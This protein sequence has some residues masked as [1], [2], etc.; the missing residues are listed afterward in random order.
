[1]QPH[2]FHIQC[3]DHTGLVA[4]MCKRTEALLMVMTLCLLVYAAS[5]HRIR[6]ELQRQSRFFPD[7]KRKPYQNPTAR[8]VFFCFQGINVLLVDG[9]EKTCRWLAREAINHHFSSWATVP[10]DLFL[11]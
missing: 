2:Q 8:W 9:L 7:M 11:I 4:G 1:M 3:I 10:R 5:Q 6:H